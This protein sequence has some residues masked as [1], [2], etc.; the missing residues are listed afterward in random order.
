MGSYAGVDYHTFTMG[1]PMPESTLT[2]CQC[3]LYPPTRDLDLT[4][5]EAPNIKIYIRL[6]SSLVEYSPH[7]PV[8]SRGPG[9]D[10][11]RWQHVCCRGAL[12]DDG[13]NS[14]KVPRL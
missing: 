14:S 8:I 13:E 4:S 5:L 2:Q 7:D 6:A 9:F 3:R 11:R 1:S 12:P 10:S